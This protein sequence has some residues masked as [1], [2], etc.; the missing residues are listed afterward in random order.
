MG[1]APPR[2]WYAN[3]NFSPPYL[4]VLPILD[5]ATGRG[6]ILLTDGNVDGIITGS[7]SNFHKKKSA[8]YQDCTQTSLSIKFNAIY[9]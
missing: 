5:N 8:K 6:P 3:T 4:K 2:R 7:D 9:T 1:K